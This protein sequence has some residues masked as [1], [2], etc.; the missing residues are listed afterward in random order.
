MSA[1]ARRAE[2]APPGRFRVL[3]LLSLAEL[4]GMSLWFS[5]SAVAPLL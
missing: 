4:F 2:H 1:P 5:A 3:A